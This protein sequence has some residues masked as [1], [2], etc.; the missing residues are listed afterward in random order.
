MDALAGDVCYRHCGG[1]KNYTIVTASIDGFRA[2][3]NHEI[4][5]THDVKLLAYLT[6]VGTS[7]MEVTID[8]LTC[9]NN[10]E[11]LLVGTTQ[12]IMVA[13]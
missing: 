8:V 4:T 11:E 10:T 13:R 5:I 12:F 7:S 9:R 1:V 6:Y 2:I 3:D